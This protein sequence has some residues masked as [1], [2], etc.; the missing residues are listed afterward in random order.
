MNVTQDLSVKS[1]IVY[2]KAIDVS[3]LPADVKDQAEGLEHLYAVHDA[4]GTRL[5]LV[6]DRD[7]AFVLARQ[8]DLSPQLVH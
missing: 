5:A 8:H 4:N 2:V 1:N 7:L 6:A 3:D